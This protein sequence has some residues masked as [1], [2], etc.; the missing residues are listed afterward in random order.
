MD[1]G[2]EKKQEDVI[3][4][5]EKNQSIETDPQMS[6]MLELADKKFKAAIIAMFKDL[7]EKADK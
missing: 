2:Y 1:I 3:Q 4:S 7:K 6:Q 5:Q